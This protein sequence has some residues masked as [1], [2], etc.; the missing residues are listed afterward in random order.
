MKSLHY[1]DKVETAESVEVSDSIIFVNSFQPPFLKLV[2]VIRQLL[3]KVFA[4]SFHMTM[5]WRF[6]EE[7]SMKFGQHHWSNIV[8]EGSVKIGMLSLLS[9]W[10]RG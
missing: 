2:E 1:F 4:S 6:S 7:R 3:T 9:S 10:R 8:G 5:I